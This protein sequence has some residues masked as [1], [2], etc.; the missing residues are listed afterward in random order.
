MTG[1][2]GL[3]YFLRRSRGK[4]GPTVSSQGGSFGLEPSG[5]AFANHYDLDF[6]WSS[7]LIPSPPKESL[8]QLLPMYHINNIS[9]ASFRHMK[10]STVEEEESCGTMTSHPKPTLLSVVYSLERHTSLRSK[11]H[12]R[13]VPSRRFPTRPMRQLHLVRLFYWLLL[14]FMQVMTFWK[15][16]SIVVNWC[17]FYLFWS[18][19]VKNHMVIFN[20]SVSVSG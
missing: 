12:L 6:S 1:D 18:T 15:N 19:Y 8:M 20:A 10:S 16:W 2:H 14:L 13:I 11:F 7:L 17:I 5:L 9:Y 3:L 4:Y